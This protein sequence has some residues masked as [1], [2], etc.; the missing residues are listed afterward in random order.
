MLAAIALSQQLLTV[1]DTV[2]TLQGGMWAVT[3]AELRPMIEDL[4]I[5]RKDPSPIS[6]IIQVAKDMS[7]D[8]KSPITLIAV[9]VEMVQPSTQP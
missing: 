1:R 7:A 4:M 9:G 6:A 3:V 2:K 8:G 5:L